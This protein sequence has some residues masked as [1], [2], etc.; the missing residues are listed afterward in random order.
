MKP[1]INQTQALRPENKSI[2]RA[3][4]FTF[5]ILILA[6][7][8][9]AQEY[10]T[11]EGTL[12]QV[13]GQWQLI[14]ESGTADVDISTIALLKRE[15]VEQ[16][17]VEALVAQLELTE[18]FAS[19]TGWTFYTLSPEANYANVVSTLLSESSAVNL[20]L[21]LYREMLASPN[22]P[23][24]QNN[25]QWYIDKI[26]APLAWNH[27]YGSSSV[28]IAVIDGGIDINHEDLGQGNDSYNNLVA[29]WDFVDNDADPRSPNNQ[30]HGS[31]VAGIAAAKT[32][33]NTGIAG[34][35]GGNNGPGCKI[36]PLRAGA[37]GQMVTL[38]VAKA[39]EH[40]KDNGADIINMS[41]A[42]AGFNQTEYAQI[43]DAYDAGIFLVAGSG[44]DGTTQDRFPAGYDEVFCVGGTNQNDTRLA[45]ANYGKD[46]L[47]IS[48]PGESIK[49]CFPNNNYGLSSG[50][51]MSTPMVAATVA[52]MKSVNPCLGNEQIDAILKESAEM[53]GGYPYQKL[54][55]TF[56]TPAYEEVSEELGHGR[57]DT[58]DAVLKALF[59]K[60]NTVDLYIRDKTEDLGFDWSYPPNWDWDDSPDIWVQN[61]YLTPLYRYQHDQD[62][63]FGSPIGAWVYVQVHNKSCVAY[64][65][66][67]NERLAV[68]WTRA[69]TNASWTAGN[70]TDPTHTL[71]HQ[72]N[73]APIP[74]LAPGESAVIP[75]AWDLS[76]LNAALGENI[77]LLARIEN[78]TGDP[79]TN[80]PNNLGDDV[81]FN[82]NIAMKNL[83]V[84]K[85][86]RGKLGNN[87]NLAPGGH[88]FI[89][90]PGS[91]G[92]VYDLKFGTTPWSGVGE[93][94]FEAAEVT[95]HVDQSFW[96]V[97]NHS[98]GFSLSGIEVVNDQE[99]RVLSAD[100]VIGGLNFQPEERVQVYAGFSFL[101]EF[102]TDDSTQFTFHI[103]QF[104]PQ[105]GAEAELTGGVHFD[106]TRL[107]REYF[108]ADAG[109]DQEIY[110]TETATLAAT[111]IGE[112]ATYNWYRSDSLLYSGTHFTDSP[113]STTEYTLE[114]I[115][116]ADQYKDYDQVKVTVKHRWITGLSPNPAQGVV[117]LDYNLEPATQSAQVAVTDNQGVVQLTQSLSLSANH[118]TLNTTALQP[119]IYYVQLNANGTLKQS[120]ILVIQ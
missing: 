39:I 75:L 96:D 68:Y 12:K 118:A 14:S 3:L 94:L 30:P 72:V 47:G 102:V 45:T 7:G 13:E 25:Q 37:N 23:E 89:G 22:D 55:S 21:S 69:S 51:S 99:L 58:E 85:L 71:G 105:P 87:A 50:T 115:A 20:S 16:S 70:F 114:V 29:G 2:S 109:A 77:C 90:E 40:A 119:G 17:E 24:Y 38:E 34:V 93:D 56:R 97:A 46:Y 92:N 28:T 101:S 100:A 9:K 60:S 116:D 95:L 61:K 27:S 18:D 15:G 110:E 120:R 33:N 80:H 11:P 64:T 57:L 88:V 78:I 67:G 26:K 5:G 32:N 42:G 112:P 8:S 108:E 41:F 103:R 63:E 62:L 65:P 111:P 48:A 82:N 106:L 91:S 52:L 31:H 79:I 4:F 54:A 86:K 73:S 83:Q 6:L 113:D 98:P 44:K 53:T 1:T 59:F 74:A 107:P 81:Y 19:S 49:S 104:K 10:Q 35:A 43:K 36:M 66:S 76:Q 117:H 84:V